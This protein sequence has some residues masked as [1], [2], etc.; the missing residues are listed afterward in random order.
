[1]NALI[2]VDVEQPKSAQ[3]LTGFTLFSLGNPQWSPTEDSIAFTSTAGEG[4]EGPHLW[5]I[6]LKGSEKQL[7]RSLRILGDTPQWSP[8]GQWIAV[9]GPIAYEDGFPLYDIW[10][11][12][13]T[14]DELRRLTG[15]ME[16]AAAHVLLDQFYPQWSPLGDQVLY[17]KTTTKEDLREIWSVALIDG[18]RRRLVA[19]GKP[20]DIGLELIQNE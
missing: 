9:A 2:I 4:G 16:A 3:N 11:V 10:L 12:N 20:F 19:V 1:M 14:G 5:R 13:H 18:A 8:D 6:E 7:S 15:D 17:L